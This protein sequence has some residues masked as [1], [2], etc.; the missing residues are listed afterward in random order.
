MIAV[1]NRPIPN[2]IAAL[3]EPISIT[4]KP[5]RCH[6]WRAIRPFATPSAN[7]A[8]SVH[9]RLVIRAGAI[10]GSTTYGHSGTTAAPI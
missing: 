2:P 10:N 4:C 8:T 1:T 5:A 9:T 7:S 3:A 6:A